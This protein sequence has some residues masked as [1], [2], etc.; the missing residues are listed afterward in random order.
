LVYRHDNYNPFDVTT[1]LSAKLQHLE[2]EVRGA[3]FSGP[4]RFQES[5]TVRCPPIKPTTLRHL[6]ISGGRIPLARIK[7]PYKADDVIRLARHRAGGTHAARLGAGRLW[8]LLQQESY[9]AALAR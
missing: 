5:E 4:L 8:D 1:S 3:G 7:R 2:P 9:V 6:R